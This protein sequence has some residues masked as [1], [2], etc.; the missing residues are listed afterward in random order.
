MV[1]IP[2]NE[3]NLMSRVIDV[4]RVKA[5]GPVRQE[6]APWPMTAAGHARERGMVHPDGRSAVAG[7]R[8]VLNDSFIRRMQFR[9]SA[10]VTFANGLRCQWFG[11]VV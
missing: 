2:H 4:L 9:T 8:V 3:K 10:V 6:E 1:L 7:P 11:L 5:P